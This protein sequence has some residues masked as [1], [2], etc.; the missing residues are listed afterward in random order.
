MMPLQD[1]RTG[2]MTLDYHPLVARYLHNAIPWI[3]EIDRTNGWTPHRRAALTAR[4]LPVRMQSG[5]EGHEVE[6]FD[7]ADFNR[8][9]RN[10]N[11]AR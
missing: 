1:S 10:P 8:P 9:R 6:A 7:P 4:Y 2:S 3:D 11:A 5:A